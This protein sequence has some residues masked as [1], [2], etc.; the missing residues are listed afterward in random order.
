MDNATLVEDQTQNRPQ[1]LVETTRLENF[2]NVTNQIQ[3]TPKISSPD[4]MVIQMRGPRVKPLTW[5]PVDCN[6]FSILRSRREKT[7]ERHPVKEMKAGLRR[8]LTLSP[9]KNQQTYE[10]VSTD[11]IVYKKIRM[12]TT[13]K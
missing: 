10:K 2:Y 6:S 1:I 5:S 3:T 8:R 7:P 11:S 13:E 4:E 9:V 12:L